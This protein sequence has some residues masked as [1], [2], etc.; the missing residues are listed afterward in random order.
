MVLLRITPGI[1]SALEKANSPND[2]PQPKLNE[3]IS[4]AQLIQLSK[5]LRASGHDANLDALLRGTGVYVP[6]PAEKKAK[7][8][9]PFL[10]YC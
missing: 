4:H 5:M 3:P 9:L 10:G 8:R 6:P 7:V 1:L 2:L